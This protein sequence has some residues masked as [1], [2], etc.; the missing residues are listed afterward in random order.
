MQQFEYGGST[1]QFIFSGYF[2]QTTAFAIVAAFGCVVV[3]DLE[4]S[5]ATALCR[6]C[7]RTLLLLMATLMKIC[8]SQIWTHLRSI[9]DDIA[10]VG[11]LAHCYT[12]SHLLHTQFTDEKSQEPA[13]AFTLILKSNSPCTFAQTK[14]YK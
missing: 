3:K 2:W 11:I 12:Y 6:P 5:R 13:S 7:K 10:L 1:D 9:A 8:R 14:L 4:I